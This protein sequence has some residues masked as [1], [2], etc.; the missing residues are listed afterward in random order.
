M[1]GQ[2]STGSVRDWVEEETRHIDVVASWE[3]LCD[4]YDALRFSDRLS[5]AERLDEYKWIVQQMNSFLS[6]V[7]T[8]LLSC[9]DLE[10]MEQLLTATF[11][12]AGKMELGTRRALVYQKLRQQWIRTRLAMLA[13]MREVK[14]LEDG[15]S[16]SGDDGYSGGTGYY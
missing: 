10:A 16:D 15:W 7:R 13:Q 11:T 3:S 5:D 14:E 1:Q 2:E 12:P 8:K 4:T 9:K 6:K